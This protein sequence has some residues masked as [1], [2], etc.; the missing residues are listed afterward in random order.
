M[1]LGLQSYVSRWTQTPHP[2]KNSEGATGS[3]PTN[4]GRSYT[5]Q[6]WLI[7]D[8][9]K[10]LPAG[11]FLH[12]PYLMVIYSTLYRTFTLSGMVVNPVGLAAR[13]VKMAPLLAAYG[14][15]AILW[16]PLTMSQGGAADNADGYGKAR[17]LDIGQFAQGTRWGTAP[18]VLKANK[19][20]HKSGMMVLEDAVIHQYAGSLPIYEL[21]AK[22]KVDKALFP[23]PPSCFVPQVAVDKV[24]NTDG[25]QP[26]G[27]MVSYQNSIPPGYMLHGVVETMCW[28]RD[29]LG[30]D[31]GRLD[32]TKGEASSVSARIIDR[33]GGWWFG[34]C[35]EGNPQELARWVRESKGKRT[36]D[37]T[38]H[39]AIK[40]A[41][42][43][44]MSLRALPGN[45]FYAIDPDHSVLF[46]ESAD[47][48]NNTSQNVRWNKIWGYLLILT[49]PAAAAM[50]YAGDYEKYD[51]AN[52]IN[53]LMWIGSTM[54]FGGLRW[55]HVE[56]EVVA[57]SRDGDGGGVGQSKGLL[58]GFNRGSQRTFWC[59]TP[60]APNQRLHDYTGNAGDIWTNGDGWVNIAIPAQ[61]YV[62]YSLA[63][64]DVTIKPKARKETA[65]GDF[66]N[67]SSIE[68]TL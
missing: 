28:R 19:A 21:D 18:L 30:L 7:L 58:C 12:Y 32:D 34:E 42:E 38:L 50:V 65:T 68:A 22:G 24:F 61:G 10:A 5:C 17:D 27:Q 9:R 6:R 63:G 16:P 62:A 47:T 15:N 56:D 11:A 8:A 64:Q 66:F 29:V 45:G 46:V 57:W 33:V 25:N 35:F 54:A 67:F 53:N 36:L 44:A 49:L 60:F 51:L 43:G 48:D 13:V 23:K 52:Q 4:W 41:C 14:C 26:F 55:E 37:F 2:A 3:S 31:G 20:I 1:A 40:A 39:W 59:R